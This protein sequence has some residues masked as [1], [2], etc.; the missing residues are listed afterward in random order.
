MANSQQK[1]IVSKLR[2]VL[3][4]ISGSE[5]NFARLIGKS[6]S[7]VKKASAGIIPVPEESAVQISDAT[8]VALWWI[9]KGDTGIAP[10]EGGTRARQVRLARDKEYTKASFDRWRASLPANKEG[11]LDDALSSV[12]E[13]LHGLSGAQEKNALPMCAHLIRQCAADLRK[14][15]GDGAQDGDI[16]MVRALSQKVESLH[17]EIAAWSKTPSTPKGATKDRSRKAKKA[18]RK[19]A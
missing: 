16:V 3:G 5:R 19:K 11:G 18:M 6:Q 10:A 4:P 13:I 8:G 17:A 12:W 2:A 9:L 14:R 7:W 15:F 1:T